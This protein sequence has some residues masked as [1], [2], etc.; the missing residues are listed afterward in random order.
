MT[1]GERI[2]LNFTVFGLRRGSGKCREEYVEVRDGHSKSSPLI[3]RYCG[4]KVPPSIWST[5]S[6]LWIRYLSGEAVGKL[7]FKA[8]YKGKIRSANNF[9]MLLSS[10]VYGYAIRH[11]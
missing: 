4:K 5:G 9:K 11:R 6:R 10:I 8:S 3:G 1:L 7:G 2:S